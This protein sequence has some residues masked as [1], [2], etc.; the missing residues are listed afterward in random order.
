MPQG[1][2]R[3]PGTS[4]GVCGLGRAMRVATDPSRD[5]LD[6]LLA[7]PHPGIA[8]Y[9]DF[10]RLKRGRRCLRSTRFRTAERRLVPNYAG[11]S[12]PEARSPSTSGSE[13]DF[14][15]AVAIALGAGHFW[16][17]IPARTS[18]EFMEHVGRTATV[19][20]P[21][22]IRRL[23][24][25]VYHGPMVATM[26]AP[27][28]PIA[29]I[30]SLTALVGCAAP[31]EPSDAEPDSKPSHSREMKC[32]PLEKS[33]IKILRDG[34]SGPNIRP[35][36]AQAVKLPNPVTPENSP[37]PR[38]NYAVALT[39]AAPGGKQVVLFGTQKLDGGGFILAADK[40]AQELFIYGADIPD[41]GAIG[42]MRAKVASSDA[43]DAARA[44]LQ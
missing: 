37:K 34:A 21:A 28:F 15:L 30:L 2:V 44:C 6:G 10:I 5:G 26:K 25:A 32:V 43:A 22:F 17:R 31:E 33:V 9:Q 38:L 24:R 12:E 7:H 35:T 19:P 14:V 1:R 40:T 27:R 16:V 39:V 18:P 41:D 29:A 23:W 8:H 4:R 42:Q 36:S 11:G 3:R 20:P 13:A